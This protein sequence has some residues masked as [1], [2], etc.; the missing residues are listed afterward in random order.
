MIKIKVQRNSG[1]EVEE[2]LEKALK[3]LKDKEK[4][5]IRDPYIKKLIKESNDL[6]DLVMAGM[7]DEI[8]EVMY[9]D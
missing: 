4:T 1:L 6:Y 8:L 2:V 9:Q 3:G 5:E 7:I